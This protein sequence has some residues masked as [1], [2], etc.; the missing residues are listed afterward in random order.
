MRLEDLQPNVAVCRTSLVEPLP[1][2]VP[3]LLKRRPS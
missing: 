1:H 3:A 2:Q